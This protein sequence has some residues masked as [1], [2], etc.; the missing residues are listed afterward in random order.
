M[1]TLFLRHGQSEA[2][3]GGWYAGHIDSPLTALG[4]SA[5][6]ALREQ[7]V[8]LAPVRVYSSDLR[9][10]SET[11]RLALGARAGM[12][13]QAQALRERFHGEWEGRIKAELSEDQARLLK[14]WTGRPPGGGESLLDVGLRAARYL[15]ARER[16]QAGRVLLVAHNGVLRTLVAAIDQA[17]EGSHSLEGLANTTLVA[18]ELPPGGWGT[19]VERLAERARSR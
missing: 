4:R 1:N 10:A 5:A 16:D 13:E 7:L 19:L 8:E 6:E 15:A 3:A 18:R 14:Q 17:L 2:N 11:A 12:V 9:R